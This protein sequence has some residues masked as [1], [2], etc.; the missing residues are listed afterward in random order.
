M[1][2]PN[3]PCPSCHKKDTLELC[4]RWKVSLNEIKKLCEFW[5]CS[6]CRYIPDKKK[7]ARL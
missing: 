5:Q 3:K 4:S 2:I 6:G 1:I 7:K